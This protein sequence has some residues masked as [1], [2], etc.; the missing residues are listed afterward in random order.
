MPVSLRFVLRALYY[1]NLVRFYGDVHLTLEETEGVETEANRTSVQEVY[2]QA[3][4]PDLEFAISNLPAVQSDYGRVTKAA[5]EFLLAK[6]HLT[7]PQG[8]AQQSVSLMSNVINNYGYSLLDEWSELWAIDNEQNSEVVWTIIN[9]KQQVDE[10]LDDYGHRGHLYFLFEYDKQPGMTR[11]TENGRPWKR[12]RPTDYLLGLWDRTKDARYDKGYK[13][14]WYANNPIPGQQ[15]GDTAVYIPGPGV[16]RNGID[17]DAKW[18]D[19]AKA[20]VLYRVHTTNN[21]NQIVFPSLNKWIDNTRPNRQHTQGQRDFILMRLADA[22]LI[23]AEANFKLGNKDQAA[24]DLNIIRRRAAWDGQEDAMEISSSDVT[25]ELI[26]DERARELV[27]EGHR[28]FDLARNN[29]LV[30]RVKAYNV[31]AKDNIQPHHKLRPIPLDQIDRTEGGY[32]QNPGYT[33]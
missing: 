24:A 23:R 2:G 33:Q 6:V 5:A 22:Y 25:L 26:L 15:L 30:E 19:A 4:I 8:D 21:Y 32:P 1:F 13:H 28:W 12:F 11:D 31:D 14:V 10:G 18:T 16:D 17:Q 7:A 3:I 27:G 20:S 9:S 29:V